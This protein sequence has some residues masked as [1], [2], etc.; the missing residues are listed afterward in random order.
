ME[1]IICV[2]GPTASGKTE[3]EEEWT[4]VRFSWF[5]FDGESIDVVAISM[6]FMVFGG[7]WKTKE[8]DRLSIR[9]FI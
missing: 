2:A 5:H 6:N 4:G 7:N 3:G 9:F 8:R 1:K